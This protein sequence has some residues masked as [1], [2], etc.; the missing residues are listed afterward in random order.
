MDFVHGI[1][2]CYAYLADKDLNFLFI[3]AVELRSH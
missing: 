2:I 3:S 1:K